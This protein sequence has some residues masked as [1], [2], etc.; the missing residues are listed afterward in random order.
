MTETPENLSKS[1]DETINADHGYRVLARKYRPTTFED[2]IGQETLV[3]TLSNAIA[4]GRIAQAYILTGVRGIGKTTTARII[5][6]ALNHTNGPTVDLSHPC[7]HCDAITNDSHVDV[8]EMDAAS[9]TGIDD[10]REMI[11]D[12]KYR[13][14]HARYKIFILDEVHMLSTNAFN[15]LLKTLE[16]PPAH[17]KF[18]F[19]TTEIRKVPIT[20]LSRCQRFDLRRIS[21]TE[22]ATHY[23]KICDLENVTADPDAITMIAQAAD[24]SVRDGLSILDQ[25]IALQTNGITGD[26]VSDMLGLTNRNKIYDL[27][28]YL[29]E[30]NAPKA[31]EIVNDMHAIGAVPLTICNDVLDAFWF[32]TK[33]HVNPTLKNDPNTPELEKTLGVALSEKLSMASLSRAWQILIKGI[34]E[35]KSAPNDLQ[36]L[37]MIFIRLMHAGTLPTPDEIIKKL[38]QGQN[39]QKT[40]SNTPPT[41]TPNPKNTSANFKGGVSSNALPQTQNTNHA[42]TA[43]DG[44]SIPNPNGNPVINPNGNPV[45]NPNGNPVINLNENPIQN[46][47]PKPR[48]YLATFRDMVNH[49][50][51]IKEGTIVMNLT[52][53]VSCLDYTMTDSNG[54]INLTTSNSVPSDFANRLKRILNAQTGVPW[55]IKTQRGNQKQPIDTLGDTMNAEKNASMDQ[56][57]NDKLVVALRGYF[58]TAKIDKVTPKIGGKLDMTNA[59]LT[60]DERGL[61]DPD[62]NLEDDSEHIINT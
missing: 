50:Q 52:H 4:S 54:F 51:S 40:P 9:H 25:A 38:N 16:E 43:P 20:I 62:A 35:I 6:K 23:H 39:G 44:D 56:A 33:C 10:I 37:E 42:D 48:V 3:R 60:A 17:V 15:A 18:I 12:V 26:L 1:N 34:D 22:L 58:P 27:I 7:D 32:M 13:P 29:M 8:V 28:E 61:S 24:G 11:N 59:D 53:D 30:G 45:N 31:L 19:A 46:N 49:L 47:T 5:A 55:T 14:M 57:E 21:T 2:M 41:N 36:A